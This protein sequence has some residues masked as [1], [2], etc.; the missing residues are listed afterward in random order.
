M[1]RRDF[2]LA[3]TVAALVAPEIAMSGKAIRTWK[4]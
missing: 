1:D 4:N 3:T 2:L